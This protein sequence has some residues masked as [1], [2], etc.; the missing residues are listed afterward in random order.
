ML[1]TPVVMLYLTKLAQV[2]QAL[3]NASLYLQRGVTSSCLAAWLGRLKHPGKIGAGATAL[4]GVLS[5][6]Y[7]ATNRLPAFTVTALKDDVTDIT[8]YLEKVEQ[9]FGDNGV[10]DFL[11]SEDH[12]R[13]RM[14][15]SRTF[16]SR[17]IGSVKHNAIHGHLFDE[18]KHIENCAVLWAKLQEKLKS[19]ELSTSVMMNHWK[20][21]FSLECDDV[22][23]FLAFHNNLKK[24]L[25]KLKDCNSIAV[26][27]DDFLRVFVHRA[28]DIEELKESVKMLVK[29]VRDGST[30]LD[31]LDAIKEDCVANAG[32]AGI[33]SA[34]TA[35]AVRSR[36]ADTEK[37]VIPSKPGYVKLAALPEFPKNVDNALDP[38]AFGQAR[39]WYNAM[40]KPNKS[41]QEMEDF[42]A[43][44]WSPDPRKTKK[45]KGNDG[46]S[47]GRSSGEKNTRRA[48]TK[49]GSSSR[50]PSP[51][52]APSDAPP[53][54]APDVRYHYPPLP[55]PPHGGYGGYGGG[56]PPGN[57]PVNS[58]HAHFQDYY[59]PRQNDYYPPNNYQGGGPG[60]QRNYD[61]RQR[62]SNNRDNSRGHGGGNN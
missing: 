4:G 55:P 45:Q 52:P 14:S 30:F 61:N 26:S 12:C 54:Q 44:K 29:P 28:L 8:S 43:F 5:E 56:G 20:T 62:F 39:R 13:S 31:Q 27:D 19:S 40:K 9:T 53:H 35:S 50:E 60:Y 37:S 18:V 34:G 41:K 24:V 57:D 49:H 47:T 48:N 51:A 7:A 58:R 32:S 46:K 59:P 21:F 38:H 10:M 42:A 33:Q 1:L 36:R 17:L 6:N 11:T 25:Q 22:N 15:F 16:C 3:N 23:S 2:T